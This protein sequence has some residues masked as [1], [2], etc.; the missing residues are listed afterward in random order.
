MEVVRSLFESCCET[1]PQRCASRAEWHAF[2]TR[3]AAADSRL[4][5]TELRVLERV[6]DRTG[7][8][9][10]GGGPETGGD[11]RGLLF[12][13]F[14]QVLVDDAASGRLGPRVRAGLAA[15]TERAGLSQALSPAVD[16]LDAS[17]GR[18]HQQLDS[19]GTLCREWAL[20]GPHLSQVLEVTRLLQAEQRRAAPRV[21]AL[22]ARIE[23]AYLGSGGSGGADAVARSA[24][25]FQ[26]S[27][28]ADVERVCSATSV[29]GALAMVD[30]KG[31]RLSKPMRLSD[32]LGVA[33]RGGAS[34]SSSQS[35]FSASSLLSSKAAG[36]VTSGLELTL[37]QTRDGE[38]V[39]VVALNGS[40]VSDQEIAFAS[41]SH[42]ALREL[43]LSRHVPK[44]MGHSRSGELFF[45]H[46]V[47]AVSVE[48][49]LHKHGVL[50]EPQPLLQSI[51]AQA[52]EALADVL[53]QSTFELLAP[54]SAHNLFLVND[55][56]RV[57]LGRLEWGDR[58]EFLGA[59]DS[60]DLATARAAQA[61]LARWHRARESRLL[62]DLGR[63]LRALVGLPP[64]A[65]TQ[66]HLAASGLRPQQEA[67][68]T[69]GHKQWVFSRA[70]CSG[71]L[72]VA[73]GDRFRLALPPSA[74]GKVWRCAKIADTGAAAF[75]STDAAGQGQG[76][77]QPHQLATRSTI[78]QLEAPATLE[79]LARRPGLCRVLLREAEWWQAESDTPA[80]T[81]AQ[82]QQRTDDDGAAALH[83]ASMLCRIN[84][85]AKG[86]T[87]AAERAACSP[88][89]LALI[90]TC[91]SVH[92]DK[93]ASGL[94]LRALQRKYDLLRLDVI[95]EQRVMDDLA[96]W[97][98]K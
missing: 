55:G 79:F 90:A 86:E 25:A 85:T 13:E 20:D 26:L 34:S 48:Q 66:S 52:C 2:V 76:K 32:R 94:T 23:A 69:D 75:P 16:K 37:G 47:G 10:L 81:A 28:A 5:E 38:L 11:E 50:V 61:A 74:P 17:L 4:G 54:I 59:L 72:R 49:L 96:A 53:E 95:D 60:H 46:L 91:C 31:N 7:G 42:A 71:G 68:P 83:G 62:G 63:V 88:A 80:A 97:T 39:A 87:A 89:L 73:E 64:A 9:A 65:E 51:A 40:G 92:H 33:V 29:R 82:L 44:W 41:C 18:V 6:W 8:R 98:G 14:V 1:L 56:A 58:P 84:V 57:V 22:V 27:R 30:E 93:A 43:I 36:A 45:E 15:E 70:Q 67:S 78:L 35:S 12:D 19:L 3:L 24:A 77:G 21:S